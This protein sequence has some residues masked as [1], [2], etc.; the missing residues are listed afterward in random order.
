MWLK[1]HESKTIGDEEL[2]GSSF[3]YRY[4]GYIVF[5]KPDFPNQ[6]VSK[7]SKAT[8]PNKYVAAY[9]EEEKF[10]R[11]HFGGVMYDTH[12]GFSEFTY[13]PA[14]KLAERKA[15]TCIEAQCMTIK[16]LVR[17]NK[18]RQKY[19]YSPLP[20]HRKMQEN[21]CVYVMYEVIDW[22][23]GE[24]P[25]PEFLAEEYGKTAQEE[26]QDSLETCKLDMEDL[27][28]TLNNMGIKCHFE[29]MKFSR[30]IQMMLLRKK[31]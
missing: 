23:L 16:E 25:I 8:L 17:E 28:K 31:R 1:D 30:F 24:E 15:V 29:E 20:F 7:V 21:K 18:L 13:A 12:S 4:G 9:S 14:I 10:Y 6:L 26:L 11:H 22:I 5:D 3:F 19:D 27:I 2:Q